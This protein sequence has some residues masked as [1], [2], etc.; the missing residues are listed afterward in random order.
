MRRRELVRRLELL[1]REHGVSVTLI[2]EGGAHTVYVVGDVR[3][4]VPRHR[5]INELTAR[6]IIDDVRRRL[7]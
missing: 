1:A 6:G 5:E 3:V 2:R 7:G 4:V